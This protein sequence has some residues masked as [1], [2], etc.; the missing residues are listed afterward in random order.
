MQLQQCVFPWVKAKQKASTVQP[1]LLCWFLFSNFATFLHMHNIW[2][3][4]PAPH[5]PSISTPSGVSG[6]GRYFLFTRGG[7]NLQPCTQTEARSTT[8]TQ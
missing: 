6:R 1:A 3:K 4:G 5:S 7:P 2:V 8:R